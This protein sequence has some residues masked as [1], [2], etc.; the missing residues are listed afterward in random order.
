MTKRS[1][2]CLCAFSCAASFA[3][4]VGLEKLKSENKES[5]VSDSKY[6]VDSV[7]KMECL[8]GKKKKFQPDRKNGIYGKTVGCLS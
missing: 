2:R 8:D 5:V 6:V 3:V 1:C 7:L 4:I